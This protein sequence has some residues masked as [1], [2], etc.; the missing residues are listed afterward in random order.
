MR[1]PDILSRQRAST[2]WSR[3]GVLTPS[4]KSIA[5]H[6]K[7]HMVRHSLTRH[8][9]FRTGC[10]LRGESAWLFLCSTK[11]L[12]CGCIVPCAPRLRRARWRQ[13]RHPLRRHSRPLT[14]RR[15]CRAGRPISIEEWETKGD[16]VRKS[17]ADHFEKAIVLFWRGRKSRLCVCL[18]VPGTLRWCSCLWCGIPWWA[19]WIRTG[20]GRVGRVMSV[21]DAVVVKSWEKV[22][23]KKE[24]KT[25]R[26]KR[27]TLK[28][29]TFAT[30]T[31]TTK[32]HNNRGH[33]TLSQR[34]NDK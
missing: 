9:C 4:D 32:T 25:K 1:I 17:P 19:C 12:P 29:R 33:A 10:L 21:S 24:K 26:K 16:R 13:S 6:N 20:R 27:R 18:F 7:K 11:V 5:M 2:I 30:P 22:S 8:V 31:T 28:Y 15:H 34:H 23:T 3:W 14:S